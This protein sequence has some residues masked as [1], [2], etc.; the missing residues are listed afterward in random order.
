MNDDD[1]D[2]VVL[3]LPATVTYAVIHSGDLSLYNQ[4]QQTLLKSSCCCFINNLINCDYD[5]DW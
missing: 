1:L 4:Q 2:Y 3:Y 5:D